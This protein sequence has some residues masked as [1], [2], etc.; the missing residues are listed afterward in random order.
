M[1][2]ITGCVSQRKIDWLES[3][4]G[5]MNHRGPDD[6]GVFF[7]ENVALGMTRL[8]IQDLTSNGHQ[9]MSTNDNR[10]TIVYN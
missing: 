5:V 10:Y 2:G 8:S 3:G 6:S 9:P 1:C 4:V 7:D